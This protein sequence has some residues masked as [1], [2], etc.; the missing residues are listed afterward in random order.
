MRIADRNHGAHQARAAI[1][2]HVMAGIDPP[3][4][5]GRCLRLT[6]RARASDVVGTTL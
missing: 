1:L 4:W 5:G 3:M 2:A 6:V